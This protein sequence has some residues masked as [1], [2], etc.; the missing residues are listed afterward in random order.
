MSDKN[1][2]VK[3]ALSKHEFNALW[4][5]ANS[6][7]ERTSYDEVMASEIGSP[8]DKALLGYRHIQQQRE[9]R[10]ANEILM[11]NLSDNPETHRSD[12]DHAHVTTSPKSFENLATAFNPLAGH[13]HS[14]MAFPVAKLMTAM[15][16][17]DPD[18]ISQD[19]IDCIIPSM[20]IDAD[21]LMPSD[22]R[23]KEFSFN[24]GNDTQHIFHSLTASVFG[25]NL[26][27]GQRQSFKR[28]PGHRHLTENNLIIIADAISIQ[29]P[30]DKK[31]AHA[32]AFLKAAYQINPDPFVGPSF[33]AII[34]EKLSAV[35]A[36]Q[37]MWRRH[38]HLLNNLG[39]LASIN[40][41]P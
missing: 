3:N 21:T 2:P 1:F 26:H 12:Y 24:N 17:K 29:S 7:I 16:L 9:S 35:T 36:Q 40:H 10:I 33:K 23:D 6:N 38:Q 30:S 13:Y 34:T 11:Q 32:I 22:P 8:N 41:N 18:V 14:D 15:A 28:H 31:S 20:F 4:N 19:A 27:P 37:N 39:L 25:I 5:H